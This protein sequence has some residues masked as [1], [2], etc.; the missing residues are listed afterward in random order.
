MGGNTATAD[1]LEFIEDV[2]SLENRKTVDVD[3]FMWTAMRV[4]H[5]GT[6]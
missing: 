1:F 5:C 3:E 2:K 4:G 6:R